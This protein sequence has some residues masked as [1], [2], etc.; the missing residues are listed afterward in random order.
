MRVGITQNDVAVFGK[1]VSG[2]ELGSHGFALV[3]LPVFATNCTAELFS[4][5]ILR[6]PMRKGFARRNAV[7]ASSK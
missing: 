6:E 5:L 7:K 1:P 3:A 4:V 2:V